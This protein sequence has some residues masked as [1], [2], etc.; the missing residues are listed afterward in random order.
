MPVKKKYQNVSPSFFQ[1]KC[2][3]CLYSPKKR[4]KIR[5]KI[6][7]CC[8]IR[9]AS[10]WPKMHFSMKSSIIAKRA[11][12]ATEHPVIGKLP[13][14]YATAQLRRSL[15]HTRNTNKMHPICAVRIRSY[16]F[17][18]F[19]S[20]FSNAFPSYFSGIVWEI[21]RTTS[22]KCNQFLF[23]FNCVPDNNDRKCKIAIQVA[24]SIGQT[25]RSYVISAKTMFSAVAISM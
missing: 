5:I 4:V 24:F 15:R 13:L 21:E 8:K 18:I 17:S 9:L 3:K 25:R 2:S 23:G 10:T 6:S 1:W 14:E 19:E 16:E 11:A 20:W 7:F 22:T 12:A